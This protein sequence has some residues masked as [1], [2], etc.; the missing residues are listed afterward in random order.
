MANGRQTRLPRK[1]ALGGAGLLLLALAQGAL[2]P[3]E[4][5][6]QSA[7]S[8]AGVK[9]VHV[10]SLGDGPAADQI[11]T[12]FVEQLVK[13]GLEAVNDPAQADVAVRGTERLWV[14][15]FFQTSPHSRSTRQ[16]SYEGYLSVEVAG[17]DG[18]TLWSYLVTPGSPVEGIIH[19]LADQMA[20][21]LLEAIRTA[22]PA[23]SAPP[24]RST[25]G[26]TLLRGAG[27][28]F[29]APLYAL[30][31]QDFSKHRGDVRVTYDPVGSVAGLERLREGKTDF[32]GS[33]IPPQI[34]GAPKGPTIPTV[35]GAVVPLYNLKGV[36][37][38]N[39]TPEALA[40]I[41][42]G[43]IRKWDD[44]RIAATN[45][46]VALPGA[47]ITVVH[48]SDG[49]GTTYA[50]TDLLSKVSPEWKRRAGTGAHVEWPLGEGAEQ[51]E[52]VAR[53]VGDTP[54]AIGY[55][56]LIYAIQHQSTFAAVRNASGHFVR[57]SLAS[58]REAADGAAAGGSITN[59]A[60]AGAYPI[61]SF[62]WLLLP[63]ATD[64]P[65]KRSVELE[66]LRWI[67]TAGQKSCSALG[68]TPLPPS[69]AQQALATL[70]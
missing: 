41:Y 69:V 6:A 57:A 10:A 24:E 49:S 30:W 3:R 29:P 44:P 36:G 19:N 46:G 31:F 39:L 21:E 16:A 28:T 38:L 15:G 18:E 37:V 50:W 17:K 13:G 7:T 47:E 32:A 8:L 62:T 42:L 22:V 58:V 53:L 56:E 55:V 34:G 27:A 20:K 66:L 33:D 67:L 64:D 14:S 23:R 5:A 45:R 35:L 63:E 68:Y 60:G 54:N 65:A 4:L 40:G 26:Q 52:G 51:S 12:R 61:A 1:G 70:P 2:A 59:A 25:A 9:K 11:R 48:R 43:E